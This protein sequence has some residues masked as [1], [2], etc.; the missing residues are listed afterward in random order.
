MPQ[1]L[2]P[3][4]ESP[5]YGSMQIFNSGSSSALDSTNN[6]N[7]VD[8]QS[9]MVQIVEVNDA[10]EIHVDEDAH[11]TQSSQEAA[12]ANVSTTIHGYV[13]RTSS[14]IQD[15]GDAGTNITGNT[16]NGAKKKNLEGVSSIPT[17]NPFTIF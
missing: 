17:H 4:V 9:S 10:M 16:T 8:L 2:E 12:G 6:D 1:N 11:M 7:V 3:L 5:E 13:I 14:R 15:L